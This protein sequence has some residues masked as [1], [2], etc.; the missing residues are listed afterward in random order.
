MLLTK[1][2]LIYSRWLF[3]SPSLETV[4]REDIAVYDVVFHMV[5][6]SAMGRTGHEFSLVSVLVSFFIPFSRPKTTVEY[7]FSRYVHLF[8]RLGVIINCSGAWFNTV[9][10]LL[11]NVYT[12]PRNWWHQRKKGSKTSS[13]KKLPHSNRSDNGQT[14]LASN[15]S[16]PQ[17]GEEAMK[18][19]FACKGKDPYR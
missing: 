18:R 11:K 12:N 8:F 9:K 17:T 3:R 16:L 4:E 6:V 5:F 1:V 10:A 14:N 2:W 15:I 7:V 13:S 19:L